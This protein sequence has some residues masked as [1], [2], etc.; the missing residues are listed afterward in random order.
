M[1]FIGVD[2]GSTNIKAAIYESP[3]RLVDRQS[4]PVQYIRE[5]GFVEF[6]A[7]I[8]AADLEKLIG[9]ML[10][11]GKAEVKVLHSADKWYGVTY[12]A[13]KP[14]V[15]AALREMGAQGKYPDGLWK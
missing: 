9:A 3:M 2:L 1:Y 8:Y 4:L 10:K 5:N 12:A 13:D 11:E 15:V 6:D 7:D 14:H